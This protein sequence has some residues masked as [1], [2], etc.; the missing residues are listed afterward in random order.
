[1]T[2]RQR[3][4]EASPARSMFDI[5]NDDQSNIK[6]TINYLSEEQSSAFNEEYTVT[7]KRG[8]MLPLKSALFQGLDKFYIK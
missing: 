1:M 7:L 2:K 3:T 5:G 6:V 8:M 4:S